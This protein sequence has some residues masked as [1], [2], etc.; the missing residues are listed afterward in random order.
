M[1]VQLKH[2]S[3]P[4]PLGAFASHYWFT[5]VHP[6]RCDRWEV[7]QSR[8]AGGVSRGYL[9]CNLKA[10]DDGVGGGPAQLAMEWA[11]EAALKLRAILENPA[12]Y[13][14]CDHYLPWPGP[15]SNTFVAWVLRQAGIEFPL[16]W[17]AIGKDYA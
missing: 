16:P 3:L 12:G 6:G 14:H 11:G 9:H 1:V 8:N 4:F 5:V 2:A 10:P 13:P 17:R 15:N 7:W